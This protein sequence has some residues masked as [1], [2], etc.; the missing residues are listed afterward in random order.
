MNLT[1]RNLVVFEEN[2]VENRANNAANETY[3][4]QKEKRQKDELINHALIL[5]LS[6]SGIS[7]NG[8]V[9][10]ADS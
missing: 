2:L 7:A 5:L 1:C 3:Q 9:Y 10:R 6:D 4:V 8:C